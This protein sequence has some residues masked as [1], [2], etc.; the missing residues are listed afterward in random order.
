ALAAED[1][2]RFLV[3]HRGARLVLAWLA[4]LGFAGAVVIAR[5]PRSPARARRR[6]AAAHVAQSAGVGGAAAVSDHVCTDPLP[7]LIGSGERGAV[8]G[9]AAA[10]TAPR[11]PVPAPRTDC[12]SRPFLC[13][14]PT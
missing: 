3:A 6:A 13:L 10:G 14:F 8:P 1:R 5:S 9:G 7:Y 11:S 12:V 4:L 2:S